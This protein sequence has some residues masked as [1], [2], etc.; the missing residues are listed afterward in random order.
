M[1]RSSY[2]DLCRN[3]ETGTAFAWTTVFM[4]FVVGPESACLLIDVPSLADWLSVLRSELIFSRCKLDIHQKLFTFSN[5][6]TDRRRPIFHNL[7]ASW[8]FAARRLAMFARCSRTGTFRQ[9]TSISFPPPRVARA[10]SQHTRLAK[11]SFCEKVYPR[12]TQFSAA[13][14]LSGGGSII[15]RF[16]LLE[17]TF[18]E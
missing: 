3:G 9:S 1:L 10:F 13:R 4:L 12:Q 16:E 2:L 7:R 8:M 15:L 5:R 18:T 17:Q 11:I 6:L 14:I